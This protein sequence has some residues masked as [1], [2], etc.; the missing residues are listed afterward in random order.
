M[1]ARPPHCIDKWKFTLTP[2]T[3]SNPIPVFNPDPNPSSTTDGSGMCYP[4]WDGTY[5]RPI[6]AFFYSSNCTTAGVTKAMVHII[7]LLLLIEKNR[8][9]SVGNLSG[10]MYLTL[11]NRAVFYCMSDAIEPCYFTPDLSLKCFSCN[12]SC[13][14]FIGYRKQN[15]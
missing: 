15:I 11:Y 13:K 2:N 8:P 1:S 4:V 3:I 7:D 6:A 10:T 9:R 12:I 14:S 5:K